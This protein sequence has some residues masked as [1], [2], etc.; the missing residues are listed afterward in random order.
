MNKHPSMQ[1][2]RAGLLY[3]DL[4]NAIKTTYEAWG[5]ACTLEDARELFL[6]S[7]HRDMMLREALDQADGKKATEHFFPEKF[8]GRNGL[9]VVKD[10]SNK[11][12]PPSYRIYDS[13]YNCYVYPNGNWGTRELGAAVF[14][15][16]QAAKKIIEINWKREAEEKRAKIID[17]PK[18]SFWPYFLGAI[19]IFIYTIGAIVIWYLRLGI[20]GAAAW[21]R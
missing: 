15:F 6:K 10:D 12:V 7:K 21:Q 4:L 9:E 1:A 11:F 17:H 5:M 2:M 19:L 20:E 8:Y 3:Q 14:T 13:K 18:A 16:D